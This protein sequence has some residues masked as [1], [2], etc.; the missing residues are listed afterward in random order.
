MEA[1]IGTAGG[2]TSL[3]SRITFN[4]PGSLTSLILRMQYTSGYVA[5]LN[6]VRSP[7]A[8]RRARRLE[9]AGHEYR[10][11]AVQDTTYEDVDLSAY[12]VPCRRP[13][14]CWPSRR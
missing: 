12:I 9:F 5:Y 6:G 1:A 8:T 11:S 14:T 13:A 7:G 10:S 2:M 4:N 3:Y